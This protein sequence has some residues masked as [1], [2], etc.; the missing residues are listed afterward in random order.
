M[1]ENKQALYFNMTLGTI[2]II[3]V[4]IA[5]MRYLI[6]ENDNLG[7]AIILFGFIL[8]VGYINY[9]EKR[10]GIS[11]KL[12]WIRIIVSSILFLIFTYFLYF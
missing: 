12:S 10:A 4:A 6:K 9:L 7:Y 5:A 2:G 11:K 3:L 8:T 1:K